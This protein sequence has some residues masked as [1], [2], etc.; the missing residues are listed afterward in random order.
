MRV[1]Y[2]AAKIAFLAVVL[3]ITSACN[4]PAKTQQFFIKAVNDDPMIV[5]IHTTALYTIYFDH[6]MQ[7]CVMHSAYTWGESGGGTGG[8]GLGVSVFKC[9]PARLK[10]NSE[11]YD[12][13]RALGVQQF[14]L[15]TTKRP[16]A[17]STQTDTP[18]KS[19]KS[20]PKSPGKTTAT[21][22]KEPAPPAAKTPPAQVQE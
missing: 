22:A 6:G 13:Q 1:K 19:V 4:A 8:T 10:A 17:S 9:D 7:R 2:L 11:K 12:R 3:S 15:P 18:A 5:P 20:V 16:A 21:S 14:K